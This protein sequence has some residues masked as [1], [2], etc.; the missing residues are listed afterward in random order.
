ME[1]WIN[2]TNLATDE[3]HG[4]SGKRNKR[5]GVTLLLTS[6]F[7]FSFAGVF[8][9]GVQAS[10]WDVIFWRAL[11]SILF[12][13]L[14]YKSRGQLKQ[15][16]K[17]DRQGVL[18][19][20]LAVI[21]TTAFLSSFK[22]TTIAN[23]AMIYATVP[24]AAGIIGWIILGERI[25]RSEFLASIVA[26]LGVGIVI[27]G[28][29]GQIHLVGDLLATLMTICLGLVIVLFRKYPRT[30]A[31]GVNLLSCSIL[32]LMCTFLGSPT[33]VPLN[34]VI[35]LAVFGL[36]FI[37]AYITL[38]EGSK[39]LS[40]TLT[41]LLSMLE[42]PLAPVWAFIILSE[43]PDSTTLVGGAVIILA[44]LG[45]TVRSSVRTRG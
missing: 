27:Q 25:S 3:G 44:V 7:C 40:P 8:T 4:P 33:T 45:A 19:S 43:F 30:P 38:Q 18:I 42:A 36:F 1:T 2:M 6:A 9:K 13:L 24:L 5:L 32:V 10:N 12:V 26:L 34:E 39:L 11:F 16:F 14:W 29:I 31:G 28:S 17:L 21:C 20:I 41:G 37:V 22:F 23:V 35:I 15:Q